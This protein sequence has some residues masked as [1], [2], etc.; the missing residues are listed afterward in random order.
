MGCRGLTIADPGMSP[1]G[2]SAGQVANSLRQLVACAR[3]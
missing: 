1:A 3:T 2:V